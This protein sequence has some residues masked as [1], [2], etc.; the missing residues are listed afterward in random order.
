MFQLHKRY[1]T[2]NELPLTMHQQLFLETLLPEE[3]ARI[4]T[5]YFVSVLA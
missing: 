1:R 3:H 2:E 5:R 4:Q